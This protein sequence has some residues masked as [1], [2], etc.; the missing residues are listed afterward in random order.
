MK[1]MPIYGNRYISIDYSEVHIDSETNFTISMCNNF[2]KCILE[3]NMPLL[4]WQG[5]LLAHFL[6]QDVTVIH[7]FQKDAAN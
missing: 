5:H 2:L 6:V 7:F 1:N 3:E 4:F